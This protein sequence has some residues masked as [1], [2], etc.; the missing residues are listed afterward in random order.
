MGEALPV[1]VLSVCGFSGSGKTTLLSQLIP[2]LAAQ[3]LSVGVIKHDAHG[4]T[5]DQPGKDS[6]RLFRAGA[7]VCL[8]APNETFCRF[9]PSEARDLAWA[10]RLLAWDVDLLLVEG[11][12]DTPLPK[13]WLEHPKT[14]GIPAEVTEILEVLPWGSDRPRAALELVRRVFF[15]QQPPLWGGI[16]MGGQSRRMGTPK[17]LLTVGGESS[18]ARLARMLAPHVH[19]LAYLGA[20][21]LPADAPPAPQL[22]D[23]PGPGGPLAGM[24]AALRWQPAARW[25]FLPVD[26]VA[27]SEEF[28]GWFV[29]QAEPGARVVQPVREGGAVEAVFALVRPQARGALEA[30]WLAGQGP[31]SLAG[32]EK[33]A[34]VPVPST[35]SGALASANTPE[36]WARLTGSSNL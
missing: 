27:V 23:P 32:L 6:D 14:P 11:H 5:V 30:L 12:K 34:V 29:A 16:L 24:V 8:R 17:Q 13:L 31:R 21:P 15:E 9:H 7:A 10:L 4:V 1:P 2:K 20:G 25:L 22:P 36:E 28:L 3:G 18:L 33:T 26:A 19:G 35:L